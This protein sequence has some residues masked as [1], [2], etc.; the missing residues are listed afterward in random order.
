M[1]PPSKCCGD[2][3]GRA[4]GPVEVINNLGTT[5]AEYRLSLHF[6]ILDIITLFVCFN[7]ASL[8]IASVV[9]PGFL[10]FLF[11]SFPFFLI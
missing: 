10:V 11:F 7:R 8:C 9:R 1:L 2:Y 5:F 6:P 4:D 3:C